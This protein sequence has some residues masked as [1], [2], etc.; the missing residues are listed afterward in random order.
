[1]KET[2]ELSII[3]VS[4]NTKT[5]IAKCLDSIY[6][7][8][9]KSQ[10][11]FEVI[12]VDNGSTDGSLDMIRKYSRTLLIK[13]KKNFGFGYANNQGIKKSKG[14]V[15]LLLNSDIIVLDRAIENLYD[16]L[17]TQTNT[18]VG[19]KLFNNDLSPQTSCGPGY[20]LLTIFTALFLKGD[21]LHITRY[22]P[23]KIKKVD[24]VMGACIMAKKELFNKVGLFD[25]GIFM[26]MEEIDFQYRAKKLGINIIF[27]PESHFIHYGSGSSNG[28]TTPI[29]NVFRGL[30]YYYK[31]H[32]P[33]NENVILRILLVLKS[34]LAIIIFTFMNNK[35][36]RNLYL[37]A[38]NL[39]L[40]SYEII[41][42]HRQL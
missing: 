20:N 32:R 4:Y 30:I 38:L 35:S 41:N 3:I 8:L 13:N 29:L 39:S 5:L 40:S 7:S 24:W 27:Y 18:I 19:G 26:Y 11:E 28:R 36:D 16:F 23:N 6:S 15:I 25:E 42:N 31:K 37:R 14:N 17:I 12:I 2:I 22:S 10:I 21:Y 9:Q 1:M 33:Y 34:M